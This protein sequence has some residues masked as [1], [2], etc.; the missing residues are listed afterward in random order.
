M[1][2]ACEW[3]L[4]RRGYESRRRSVLPG[5]AQVRF[6]DLGGGT[7]TLSAGGGAPSA[8]E[9]PGVTVEAMD[10]VVVL[11]CPLLLDVTVAVVPDIVP[12]G[13]RVELRAERA[14]GTGAPL[15]LPL[16]APGPLT[17]R[18]PSATS[19]R[20][21]ALRDGQPGPSALAVVIADETRRSGGR[22]EVL[23][24]SLGTVHGCVEGM[25]SEDLA[26]VTGYVHDAAVS[27]ILPHVDGSPCFEGYVP[28][29][30]RR[31]GV[32]GQPEGHALLVREGQRHEVAFRFEEGGG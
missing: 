28:A 16:L 19:W 22:F 2:T 32:S 29:G 30:T 8:S 4:A 7:W 14:D 10:Q 9:P 25:R 23:Q 27:G 26:R 13:S 1:D 21:Q 20:L 6:A 3:V 17:L 15:V 24:P 31:I 12:R 11:P 18:L 5:R